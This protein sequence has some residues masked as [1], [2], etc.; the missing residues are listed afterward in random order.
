MLCSRWLSYE[1]VIRLKGIEE[2][3]EV[4]YNSR[5][6]THTLDALEEAYDSAFDLYDKLKEFYEEKGLGGIQHKRSARY[7]ILLEFIVKSHP[8]RE[9][10]YRE[11]LTYDYYLR[12]NAKTRPEFAGEYKVSKEVLRHF[13][14]AE[15]RNRQYLPSYGPYDRNQMRKMTHMEY[16]SIIGKYI[17]FDYKERNPLNQEARTCMIEPEF[18]RSGEEIR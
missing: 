5:Q 6:F 18:L 1:D 15:E 14:E 8:V 16:F 17:L 13:Y 2:M 3:V 12:E 9:D 7:A 11:L 10:Y 4:Y